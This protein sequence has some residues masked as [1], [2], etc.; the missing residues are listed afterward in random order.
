MTPCSR[1][2]SASAEP[3]FRLTTPPKCSPT[4]TASTRS[5]TPGLRSRRNR[6]K[7]RPST[8]GPIRAGV[9]PGTRPSG[10][11]A[12]QSSRASRP[13]MNFLRLGEVP[14]RRM[15]QPQPGGDRAGAGISGVDARDLARVAGAAGLDPG[16]AR[17]RGRV[18]AGD[19]PDIVESGAQPDG[20]PEIVEIAP[21]GARLLAHQVR[22]ARRLSRLRQ[23]PAARKYRHVAWPASTE[24]HNPRR[25]TAGRPCG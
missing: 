17:G 5:A 23:G 14:D 25:N 13:S 15:S 12:S 16:T 11:R 18:R 4:A 19:E 20:L 21:V 6:S 22:Q 8:P 24:R 10:A 9:V 7:P 2:L 1:A 3:A